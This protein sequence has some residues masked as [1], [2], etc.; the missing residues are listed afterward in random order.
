MISRGGMIGTGLEE[1]RGTDKQGY[2]NAPCL[3]DPQL[4]TAVFEDAISAVGS[5]SSDLP[6][7]G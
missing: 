1:S 5:A 7:S 6:I 4:Y 2:P 3:G